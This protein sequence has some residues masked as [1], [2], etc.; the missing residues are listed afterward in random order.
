MTLPDREPP[1]GEGWWGWRVLDPSWRY[2]RRLWAERHDAG[3]RPTITPF[4]CQTRSSPRSDTHQPCCG[5]QCRSGRSTPWYHDGVLQFLLVLPE[6]LNTR[7][8]RVTLAVSRM[9]RVPTPQRLQT[10]SLPLGA[11]SAHHAR[12]SRGHSA[13]V[14]TA[15]LRC[16]LA[17][18]HQQLC[19][20]FMHF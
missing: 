15:D 18:L 14:K 4:T 13:I 6:V 11:H 16:T 19:R 20:M 17:V 9:K 3:Y 12:C 8:H 1:P 10:S 7:R 2:I 5:P